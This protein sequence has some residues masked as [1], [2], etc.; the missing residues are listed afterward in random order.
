M[1][2]KDY[3]DN[4]VAHLRSELAREV[5]AH[6]DHHETNNLALTLARDIIEHRLD[7]LNH[8][9]QRMEALTKEF[10]PREIHELQETRLR[11]LETTAA[12]YYGRLWAFGVV[13]TTV[14]TV[15]AIGLNLLLRS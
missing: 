8:F 7:V 1:E 2:L 11:I 4:E 10:L 5:E 14:V 3:I 12:N 15:L 13:I 9:Q 6:K